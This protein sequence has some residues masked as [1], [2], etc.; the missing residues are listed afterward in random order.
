MGLLTSLVT[1]GP[2]TAMEGTPGPINDY[3]YESIGGG[4]TQSGERV[5][6]ESAMRLSAVYACV[7]LLA[8]MVG[9]LP[10]LVYQ[11][12]PDGG[13][14]RARDLPIYD[15]LRRRPNTYQTAKEWRS[16]G[17]E[18]L[19]LRGNFYNRMLWDRHG[20]LAQL[21]PLHPDRMTVKLL[22]SGRRGYTYRPLNGLPEALTQDEVFHILGRSRDGV[23]GCS[24]IEYAAESIGAAKAQEG[25]AARFW[26]QGMEGHLAFV[27]PNA[28]SETARK[29]NE[30]ALQQRLGGWRQAHKAVLLEGGLKPE[31][32]SVSG[33]DSQYIESRNFSLGEIARFFRVPPHLIGDIEKSSSWGRGIEQQTIGFVNFTLLPWLAT[34]EQ[35]V[36]AVLLPEAGDFFAEFLVDAL[37]RGDMAARAASHAIYVQNG[38]LSENEVREQ[39]NYNPRP[40][41]DEPR[42]SMNQGRGPDPNAPAPSDTTGPVPTDPQESA[43]LREIV[44]QAAGG[45]VRAEIVA[46]RAALK[47]GPDRL[48]ERIT[49]Y[50]GQHV[51]LLAE[52][53]RLDATTAR[54]YCAAH[55]AEVL[56]RGLDALDEWEDEAPAAL[57]A[58]V[59][60]GA[61]A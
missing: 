21:V 20:D 31:R 19:L 35:A 25:F 54:A 3:W 6:P 38:V 51:E 53:L 32:L 7:G 42:R 5:T 30:Q 27:A 47:R 17:Q 50:Y 48:A 29:N 16:M 33:R 60:E 2:I 39:L 10:L 56:E 14:D 9:T 26:A 58:L 49:G 40:G 45:A 11:R 18:H 52:R 55:C 13:K 1:G 4:I 24:V 57:A 12:R 22:D 59:L 37:M 44:I 36:D 61:S 41:L 43:R 46:L 8:D 28:L 15:L 23:Q 34:F